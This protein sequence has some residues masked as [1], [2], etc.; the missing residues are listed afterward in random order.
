MPDSSDRDDSRRDP[1]HHYDPYDDFYDDVHLYG[2][3]HRVRRPTA[4]GCLL[5]LAG[6]AAVLVAAYFGV[7]RISDS[8]AADQAFEKAVYANAHEVWMTTDTVRLAAMSSGTS[9]SVSGGGSSFLGSGAFVV[10]TSEDQR[11]RYVERR[12]DGGYVMGSVSAESAVIYEIDEGSDEEPRIETQACRV[13]SENAE[14]Q[15]WID[16]D[17]EYRSKCRSD[18]AG[19]F[20]YKGERLRVHVPAGTVVDAFSVDAGK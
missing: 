18:D 12:D 4:K 8:I 7:G 13:E 20:G 16:E 10:R 1:R 5:Q 17:P 11:L 3:R 15:A 9:T 6:L 19:P 14:D 2:S